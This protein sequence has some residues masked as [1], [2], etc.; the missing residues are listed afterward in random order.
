MALLRSIIFWIFMFNVTALFGVVFLLVVLLPSIIIQNCAR[1][2]SYVFV[3]AARII[4]GVQFVENGKNY[5]PNETFILAS[6]HQSAW[7]TIAFHALFRHPCYVLKKELLSIPVFGQYLRQLDMIII[8][9]KAG[10]KSVKQISKEINKS[11]T[12]DRTI[13]I[14]PEGTRTAPGQI[15]P[16]RSGVFMLYKQLDLP[17]IP[18]SLDSGKL[19]KKNSFIIQKGTIIVTYHPAVAKNLSKEGLFKELRSKLDG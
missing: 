11:T 10:V 14:F 15:E 16:Y 12:Q 9:R 1:A 4:C 17:L 7:E 5:I 2:W 6:K 8:D 19:W 13:I 3:Y 18:A